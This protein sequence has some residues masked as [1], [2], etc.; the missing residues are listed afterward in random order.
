[1]DSDVDVLIAG[2]GLVGSSLAIA[3]D[4]CGLSVALIEA[5]APR[6]ALPLAAT[7]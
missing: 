5:A 6:A 2:G 7:N 4:G 3:L 1:M